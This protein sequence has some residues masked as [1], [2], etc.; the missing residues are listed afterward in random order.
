MLS[1][2]STLVEVWHPGVT[3]KA[4]TVGRTSHDSTVGAPRAPI[5]VEKAAF[6]GAKPVYCAS[7]YERVDAKLVPQLAPE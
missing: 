1:R 4:S 5:S 3:G 2:A 6:V 7:A